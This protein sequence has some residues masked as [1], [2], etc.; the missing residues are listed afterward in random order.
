ML[1]ED[2]LFL[3]ILI[4]ASVVLGGGL[5]VFGLI[6]RQLRILIIVGLAVPGAMLVIA[7][8]QKIPIQFDVMIVQKPAGEIT[9]RKESKFVG[10]EYEFGD[11]RRVRLEKP[12]GGPIATVVV[13]DTN[14]RLHVI[15]V[16]YAANPRTPGFGDKEITV[17]D[18]GS[19]G[20]TLARIEHVGPRSGGPPGS[21]KSLSSF[22]T[23]DWLA[24]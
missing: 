11:G 13:N 14:R 10:G 4:Y 12:A 21:M 24:W 3:D 2:T 17:I 1:A 23:L 16:S 5:I 8:S 9:W 18:A 20:S 6:R 15:R 22:D 7:V 19:I